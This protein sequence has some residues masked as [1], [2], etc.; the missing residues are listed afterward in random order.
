MI[1]A[2]CKSEPQQDHKQVPYR[3]FKNFKR[4]HS[5]L[6][7][8]RSVVNSLAGDQYRPLEMTDEIRTALSGFAIPKTK[9]SKDV[10]STK[11]AASPTIP[12]PKVSVAPKVKQVSKP[13]VYKSM[14]TIAFKRK[15]RQQLDEPMDAMRL[16]G[17]AA[18]KKQRK[19]W[20][21]DP[22]NRS[23]FNA[24]L[25]YWAQRDADLVERELSQS[26]V[27]VPIL[28]RAS[29]NKRKAKSYVIKHGDKS[30]RHGENVWHNRTQAL[31]QSLELATPMKSK[32]YEVKNGCDVFVPF[33]E[34]SKQTVTIGDLV[35]PLQGY[36]TIER[37]IP[38]RYD[39]TSAKLRGLASQRNTSVSRGDTVVPITQAIVEPVTEN[40]K[41]VMIT[42]DNLDALPWAVGRIPLCDPSP[43]D[44]TTGVA[45]TT[46]EY[47][48]RLQDDINH[49]IWKNDVPWYMQDKVVED[50]H[51]RTNK[52]F[53][54]YQR[55]VV[56]SSTHTTEQNHNCASGKVTY[57]SG[58]DY[59]SPLEKELPVDLGFAKN[60]VDYE[61]I[62]CFQ[63]LK[64]ETAL[65]SHLTMP[66]L[67][68][69]NAK[70]GMA[71]EE[72][73]ATRRHRRVVGKTMRRLAIADA[74]KK[75]W[76]LSKLPRNRTKLSLRLF[77]PLVPVY[78]RMMWSAR[79]ADDS[80]RFRHRKWITQDMQLQQ[81]FSSRTNNP[82]HLNTTNEASR[83]RLD[84]WLNDAEESTPS[85]KYPPKP[86]GFVGPINY[87]LEMEKYTAALDRQDYANHWAILLGDIADNSDPRMSIRREKVP[88]PVG[89]PYGPSGYQT[90]AAPVYEAPPSVDVPI[91]P[92]SD[93]AEPT[94]SSHLIEEK[95]TL[96]PFGAA[97]AREN[98]NPFHS[99]GIPF[100]K[101]FTWT[102]DPGGGVLVA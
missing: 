9:P 27:V 67:L 49:I 91:A 44:E 102:L 75:E 78:H 61:L 22:F 85:V 38:G 2:A 59:V 86:S 13:K 99:L 30:Y 82:Q 5:L 45:L 36:K 81:W 83:H 97:A 88:V 76:D 20:K 48:C 80:Y 19:A 4:R 58:V 90:P 57:H 10:S 43:W 16:T 73:E 15:I 25:A 60:D 35:I 26:E 24:E 95:S 93:M 71:Y 68:K 87:P 77:N 12:K 64:R 66:T 92:S 41:W 21:S 3:N 8:T 54:A 69:L 32:L 100:L 96:S 56:Y 94:E 50:P 11:K 84:A 46:E 18:N 14:G 39:W 52:C 29:T 31:E 55:P 23:A 17:R 79:I 63:A 72:Y 37:W 53:T 33:E 65:E 28:L 98:T 62:L 89:Q 51:P 42:Q 47:D 6:T 7:G 1:A 40:D 101:S 70:Y 74:A 34:I